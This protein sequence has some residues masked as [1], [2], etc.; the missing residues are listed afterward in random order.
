MKMGGKRESSAR[1]LQLEGRRLGCDGGG[2][3]GGGEDLIRASVV[4]TKS[5]C[6]FVLTADLKV[7]EW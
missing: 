2:G 1:V 6:E 7:C 4:A 5:V 3:G